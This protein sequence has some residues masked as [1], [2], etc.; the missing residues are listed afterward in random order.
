MR[1]GEALTRRAMEAQPDVTINVWP[2]GWV[3]QAVCAPGSKVTLA[4][5]TRAG[6]GA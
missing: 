4:P 5:L 6:S 2:S 1:R 3:C